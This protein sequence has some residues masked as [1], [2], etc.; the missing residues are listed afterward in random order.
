MDGGTTI[1]ACCV[2]HLYVQAAI[3]LSL[4]CHPEVRGICGLNCKLFCIVFLLHYFIIVYHRSFTAVRMTS[5]SHYRWLP[6]YI[7][8]LIYPSGI[9]SRNDTLLIIHYS[10]LILKQTSLLTRSSKCG[11]IQ[12][13][14]LCIHAI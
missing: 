8:I 11:C 2:T 7:Q 6:F 3:V 5:K 9:I 12:L 10:S 13:P 14:S 4:A 1:I